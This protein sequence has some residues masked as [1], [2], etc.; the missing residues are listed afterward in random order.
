MYIKLNKIT[1]I[2]FILILLSLYNNSLASNNLIFS[3][4]IENRNSFD[5]ISLTLYCRLAELFNRNND[6]CYINIDNIGQ[7]NNIYKDIID[8]KSKLTELISD[9][10]AI[11]DKLD[12]I[13]NNPSTTQPQSQTIIKYVSGSQPIKRSELQNIL[14]TG[15]FIDKILLYASN[16]IGISSLFDNGENN[17]MVGDV[18]S[19]Q[20]FDDKVKIYRSGTGDTILGVVAS[21][22][23]DK[24]FVI[25]TGK[26]IVNSDNVNGDIKA[27]DYVSISDVNKG[28][29]SKSTYS[30]DYIV[31]LAMNNSKDKKVSILLRQGVLNKNNTLLSTTTQIYSTTSNKIC[32]EDDCIDRNL[33]QKLIQ[34]FK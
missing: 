25:L 6:K 1:K 34:Y 21:S 7:S 2:L 32:I 11:Y 29:V 10:D 13:N 22:T 17:I 27:G 5:K 15:P 24:S 30:N 26:T 14:L 4:P 19:V 8:I 28:F 20:N 9:K 23:K 12:N 16:T 18:V 3:P 33:I 31:G